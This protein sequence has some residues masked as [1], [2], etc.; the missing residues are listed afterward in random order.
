MNAAANSKKRGLD[1]D[2]LA[3]IEGEREVPGPQPGMHHV[4]AKAEIDQ[5]ITTAKTYPRSIK[6]FLDECT[7][8]ATLTEQVAAE[9]IYA[10]P[11][12]GK[13]IEGPSARL[14]EI[15][16]SAWGN[17]RAAARIIDEGP[18]FITAQ[19]AFHDLERNVAIT[20]EV[21]RRITGKT[22]K[23]FSADMIAVTGNAA[24]SIALRSAV[25]RGVPK[26][27]WSST[28][29]AAR[30]AAVG[31]VQTIANKRATALG[32]LQKM[33]ATAPMVFAFLGVQGEQDITLDHLATLR[34]IANALK[35]G[36]ITIEDA[37]APKQGDQKPNPLGEIPLEP[38]PL[39][40]PT[41]PKQTPTIEKPNI[42]R[43][44]R[45]A[46]TAGVNVE[47]VFA[48]AGRMSGKTITGT[49]DLAALDEKTIETLTQEIAAFGPEPEVTR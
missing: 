4:L 38:P 42:E 11:R 41:S 30:L 43:L 29:E 19:G 33:G 45:T 15:V 12:D 18:E 28:Y 40:K 16:A 25:F 44:L 22:G 2:D 14:A 20:Y 47:E 13:T 26:A 35:E 3:G 8:M 7:Q 36:E 48:A 23:R 17:C 9:C 37:F 49:R 1:H 31:S 39:R 32:F 10:V 24:C 6:R 27:F 21:R 34:G 46:E 5:Q